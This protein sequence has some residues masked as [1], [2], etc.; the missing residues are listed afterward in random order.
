MK[1]TKNLI[2][3][4][5]S[6]LLFFGWFKKSKS[7]KIDFFQNI[8]NGNTQQVVQQ[9]LRT[10]IQSFTKT[11]TAFK[12]NNKIQFKPNQR[13][14]HQIILDTYTQ[15]ITP[16]SSKEKN[17]IQL[18]IE[19]INQN[20]PFLSKTPW[21]FIKLTGQLEKNMPFTLGQFIFLPEKMVDVLS[22]E[23]KS[24]HLDTLIH[25]KIHVLQR[26]YPN[27]FH[28]FYHKFIGSIYYEKKVHIIRYWK[29]QHLK[30]P[31]GMDINWIYRHGGNF[32]LPMLIFKNHGR[33]IEQIVILLK[34]R[35]GLFYT[36]KTHIPISEFPVFQGYPTYVSCYHPNEISACVIPKLLWKNV[37][38]HKLKLPNNK[39]KKGFLKLI[40]NLKSSS[41]Y[42]S[43]FS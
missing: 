2:Y 5:L 8:N 28:T 11:E 34:K 36:T 6:L 25:E 35:Y 22:F 18:H 23:P 37:D 26:L 20:I 13:I 7:Y 39:I 21:R 1:I 38:N 42:N 17:I 12:T 24:H 10:Y 14:N 29:Q 19:L 40:Q 16:F 32:Y 31:D 15:S 33:S 43:N 9:L 4:F 41:T 3:V 30:N 27:L